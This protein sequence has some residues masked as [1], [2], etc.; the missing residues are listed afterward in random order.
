MALVYIRDIPINPIDPYDRNVITHMTG[1]DRSSYWYG[2]RDG[3]VYIGTRP[4][5]SFIK[6]SEDYIVALRRK[7]EEI[8]LPISSSNIQD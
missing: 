2:H 5:P 1:S 8:T 4:K 6:I 7:T 3:D